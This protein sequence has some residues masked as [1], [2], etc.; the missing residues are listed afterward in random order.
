MEHVKMA[1]GPIRSAFAGD[2]DM[3]ELVREFVAEMPE[4]VRGLEALWQTQALEDLRRSAHQLKGSGGG[5]GFGPLSEAAA[6]LESELESLGRGQRDAS[7]MRL[8][9]AYERLVGVCRRV[10]A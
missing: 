2:A 4:R 10:A 5:Y 9:E 3:A 8:R 6:V 1:S 7:T